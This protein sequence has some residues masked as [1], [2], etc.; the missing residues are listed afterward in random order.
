MHAKRNVCNEREGHKNEGVEAEPPTGTETMAK[1]ASSRGRVF[2]DSV[3]TSIGSDAES[4]QISIGTS[5]V[6]EP[7]GE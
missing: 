3:L 1:R 7:R 5:R 6:T 2:Q 4:D